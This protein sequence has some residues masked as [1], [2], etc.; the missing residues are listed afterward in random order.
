[1]YNMLRAA[2]L[3]VAIINFSIV[4]AL[5]QG[6]AFTY[7]GQ[8]DNS[9]SLATGTFDLKL[10]L[11][12]AATNGNTVAGPVTNTSVGVSNGFSPRSLIL[13]MPLT[14]TATGCTCRCAQTAAAR[15]PRSRRASS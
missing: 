14:E 11:F 10:T 1:M 7:Q 5:A 4:T 15:S 6:T 2:T 3:L 13:G 9:G 12:D 8:L